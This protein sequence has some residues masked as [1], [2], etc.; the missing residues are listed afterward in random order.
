[1]SDHGVVQYREMLLR[2]IKKVQ[3]GL[4]PINLFRDPNSPIIDTKGL[5]KNNFTFW[6]PVFGAPSTAPQSR[7]P[8]RR[9]GYVC[10]F[11]QSGRPNLPQI[12]AAIL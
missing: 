5:R 2:E 9:Q 4:D 6:H 8:Q 1:M 11:A 10:G 3:Q 7:N 12:R